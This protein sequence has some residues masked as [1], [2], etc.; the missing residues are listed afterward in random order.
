MASIT[1]T[2][3]EAYLYT[4][5]TNNQCVIHLTVW[6]YATYSLNP[7][8]QKNLLM[9][10]IELLDITKSK[11]FLAFLAYVD[12]LGHVG[13]SLSYDEANLINLVSKEI[14]KLNYTSLTTV[15]MT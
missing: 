10:Q 5:A 2:F 6:L 7:S 14:L 1:S 8:Q 12:K 11:S 3:K 9:T 13:R 15:I 4:Y